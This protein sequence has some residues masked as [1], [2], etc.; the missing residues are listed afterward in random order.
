MRRQGHF[1]GWFTVALIAMIGMTILPASAAGE[2]AIVRGK[3]QA[4]VPYM[5]GGVGLEERA[6]MEKEANTYTLWLEFDLSA[7]NYL[8]G[9]E[10]Q[11]EDAKGA[12]VLDEKSSGPWLMASLPAGKYR[13]QAKARGKGIE[14]IVEVPAE[15]RVT[16]TWK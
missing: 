13:V 2:D 5:T 15:K 9:V 12:V 16:L 1:T 4:E 14:A 10:V 8:S 7:G 3:S 11:I 6:A